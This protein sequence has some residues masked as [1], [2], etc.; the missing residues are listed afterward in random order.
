M[1]RMQLKIAETDD[2][3]SFGMARKACAP[4]GRAMI[5]YIPAIAAPWKGAHRH[6][7]IKVHLVY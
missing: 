7:F 1:G 5:S 3:Q 2:F 4:T 6:K